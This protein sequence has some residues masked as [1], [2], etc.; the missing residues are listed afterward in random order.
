MISWTEEKLIKAGYKIMN[1]KITK[2]DL[3]TAEYCAA[4][5]SIVLDG[6]IMIHIFKNEDDV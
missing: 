1:A 6:L 3:S 4:D 5:L 2:I